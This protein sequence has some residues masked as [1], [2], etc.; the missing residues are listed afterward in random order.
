M[1]T[2]IPDPNHQKVLKNARP[3][4]LVNSNVKHEIIHHV[5]ILPKDEKKF[6]KI[7]LKSLLSIKWTI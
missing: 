2:L 1:N 4:P 3:E 7:Q 5:Q 6:Q